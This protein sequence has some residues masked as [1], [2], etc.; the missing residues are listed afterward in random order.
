MSFNHLLANLISVGAAVGPTTI[1]SSIQAM[2][3]VI[4]FIQFSTVDF[5]KA[6]MGYDNVAQTFIIHTDDGANLAMVNDSTGGTLNTKSD[7]NNVIG[8]MGTSIT[9]TAD[10]HAITMSAAGLSILPGNGG[11]LSAGMVLTLNPDLVTCNWQTPA[12]LINNNI[13]KN[14][15]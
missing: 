3:D 1:I 9:E 15:Q 5:K 10:N 14:R 6:I 11:P 2:G 12:F 8:N 7:Q 4:Q 13:Q